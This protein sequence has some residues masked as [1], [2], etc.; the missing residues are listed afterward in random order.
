V[1]K[2][3]AALVSALVVGGLA[4]CAYTDTPAGSVDLPNGG[5]A[6]V[7]GA[8]PVTDGVDTYNQPFCGTDW[9]S[10]H[11]PKNSYYNVYNA[12]PSVNSTCIVSEKNNAAFYLSSTDVHQPW[13]YPN[14]SSGWEWGRY[15]CTGHKG[16]CFTYPVEESADGDPVTSVKTNDDPGAY[17]TSYDI[18]FDKTDATPTGQ[19][20][21]T[22][23]MIWLNHPDVYRLKDSWSVTIEGIPFNVETW[24]ASFDGVSWNYVAYLMANPQTSVSNLKLNPVFSDAIAHGVLKP[25]WYL[26]AIDFG[27]EIVSGGTK[28]GVANYSLTGVK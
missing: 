12:S 24:V 14:I 16:A 25:S 5:Q 26:T 22:E 11:V 23:V 1:R 6:A 20:N 7:A 19:D 8:K 21:G 15:T 4:A 13:G 3:L 27:W 28:N 18:W 10:V 2:V 9:V 17:N